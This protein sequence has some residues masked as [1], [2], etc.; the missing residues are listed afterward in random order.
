ME[1]KFENLDFEK[2]TPEE[3]KAFR[4]SFNPDEMGVGEDEMEGV[5]A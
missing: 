1:K 4:M 3:L 5:E 2:M